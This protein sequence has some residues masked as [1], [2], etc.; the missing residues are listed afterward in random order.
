MPSVGDLVTLIERYLAGDLG[1]WDFSIAYIRAYADVPIM[2]DDL[3]HVL[4]TVFGV[5]EGYDPSVTR[6]TATVHDF[7]E[8]TLRSTCETA[9]ASLRATGLYPEH[10]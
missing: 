6:A 8:E 5:T 10:Q 1:A 7:T 3:F 9:L 2:S 4:E